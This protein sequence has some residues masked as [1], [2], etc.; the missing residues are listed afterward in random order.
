MYKVTQENINALSI[1]LRL[2]KTHDLGIM[3]NSVDELKPYWIS[4]PQLEST[5]EGSIIQELSRKHTSFRLPN[6]F[7]VYVANCVHSKTISDIPFLC[8]E[9][10]HYYKISRYFGSLLPR[11][12]EWPES[13]VSASIYLVKNA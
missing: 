8:F 7:H 5:E 2:S 6:L 1:G 3:A 10:D 4:G 11:R 13:I 9:S 12:D